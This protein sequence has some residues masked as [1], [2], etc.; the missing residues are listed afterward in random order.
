[1]DRKRE[2]LGKV[3]HHIVGNTSSNETGAEHREISNGLVADGGAGS[4]NVGRGIP[5]TQNLP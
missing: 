2:A 1:M 5:E 4:G 3:E